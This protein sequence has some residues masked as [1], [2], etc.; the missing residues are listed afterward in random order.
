[1]FEMKRICS[2]HPDVDVVELRDGTFVGITEEC[3]CYYPEELFSDGQCVSREDKS[4]DRTFLCV[5][6]EG[7]P[8]RK[9]EEHNIRFFSTY[10]GFSDTNCNEISELAI[11]ESITLKGVLETM[12]VVRTK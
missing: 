1:M 8:E 4:N 6:G 12:S 3:I 7:Y 2:E 9:P 11:G 10:S 5:W